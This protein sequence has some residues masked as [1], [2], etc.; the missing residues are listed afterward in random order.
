MTPMRSLR[1]P[2]SMVRSSFFAAWASSV[3]LVR[4]SVTTRSFASVDALPGWISRR[5][6]EPFGPRMSATTSSRRQPTTST[7][8]PDLPWPTAMMRSVALSS[9]PCWAEPPGRISMMV[10]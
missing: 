9:P 3:I 2:R 6:K 7:I 8:S 1:S 5:T 10:T 4:G